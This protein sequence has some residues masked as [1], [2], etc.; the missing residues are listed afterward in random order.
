VDGVVRRPRGGRGAFYMGA[1]GLKFFLVKDSTLSGYQSANCRGWCS[2]RNT[3]RRKEP[4][5][6]E[7]SE[8]RLQAAI[9]GG[10]S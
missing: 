5:S 7:E 3:E 9:E 4:D 2:Q 6:P 1:R 10:N 8:G